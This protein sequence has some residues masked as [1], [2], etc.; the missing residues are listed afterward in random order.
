[1]SAGVQSR[2]ADPAW[3]PGLLA[4][5][6]TAIESLAEELQRLLRM[7]VVGQQGLAVLDLPQPRRILV[8]ADPQLQQLVDLVEL[9]RLLIVQAVVIVVVLRT[10]NQRLETSSRSPAKAKSSG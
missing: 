5:G 8:A 6:R 2:A 10:G 3:R 7:G 9:L 1:M 4:G